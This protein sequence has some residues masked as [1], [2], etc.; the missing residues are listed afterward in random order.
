MP[1]CLQCLK[2]FPTDR[3]IAAH[4]AQK[5]SKCNSWEQGPVALPV[6][7]ATE[8]YSSTEY[9]SSLPS[10]PSLRPSDFPP[11]PDDGDFDMAFLPDPPDAMN[12]FAEDQPDGE[13]G[14]SQPSTA[15]SAAFL[16]SLGLGHQVQFFRNASR[17]YN[18]G[19]TFLDRFTMDAYSSCHMSNIYYPFAT[20]DDWEMANYLLQSHLSMAK[21][22]EYLKLNLIRTLP[23]SFHTAKELRGHAELLPP[24]LHWNFRVV[25]TSHP[26]KNPMVLYYR[27][28]LECIESL[29]NHP[30][31]VLHIDYTPFRLFTTAERIVREY[32]EW[33]SGEVVWQM[34]SKLPEGVTLCGVILSS[35][36]THITNICCGKVAHP[37][38]ISLANIRMAVRNKA[39]SHAFLLAALMPI[40]EFLH[41][42]KRMRS[43]LHARLFHQCLDIVVDPLKTA[44]RIGRMMSDPVSN[45]RYCFTPL[46]AYIV[47]TPEACMLA[48][49]CGKTSPMTMASYK[50]FGDAFQHEPRT[51]AIMLAQLA[52]ITCD[53]NDVERYFIQCELCRLSGVSEPFFRDW[54]L[55]DP[56]NFFSPEA[57][58][59]WYGEFWDHDVQW[60]KNALGSQELDFCY[61]ILHPIVGLCHFKDGITSH[62][63]THIFSELSKS[64]TF[65]CW[66]A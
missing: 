52:R 27:D 6:W 7:D 48:C 61:S 59:H 39:S 46:A 56:A 19:Q 62:Q 24:R 20:H 37:L 17:V 5:T 22:D 30:Y 60:C 51:R 63:Q 16:T 8:E 34:Q 54:P 41:P 9:T 1:N 45:V 53:P 11:V 29:F 40:T 42:N 13:Q 23:L 49:V 36:K 14:D 57:L 47:D 38:L 64:M 55:S 12:I 44:A 66:L 28:S 31:F 35:D 65:L 15:A 43:V 10:L 26:T 18:V 3:G 25:S 33:M 4:L 2:H 58:H 21:I 32:T 50:E